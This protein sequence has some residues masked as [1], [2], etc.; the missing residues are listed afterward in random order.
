MHFYSVAISLTIVC[1]A[2]LIYLVMRQEW[3]GNRTNQAFT[4]YLLSMALWLAAYVMV[5]ISANAEEALFWYR[6][7]AGV[8]SGQF[9]LYY[10][11]TRALLNLKGGR[12]LAL[13]GPLVWAL[14]VFL[15]V[16]SRQPA[17][18]AGIHR[19]VATGLFVP[20]FGP[21]MLLFAAPN[22]F[23]LGYAVY[24]LVRGYRSTRSELQR[25][26]I[27]YLLVGLVVVVIGIAVNFVP[28][29]QPYPIDVAA[30]LVNAAIIA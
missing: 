16:G 22:Y 26:R 12:T 24:N 10:V 30:N 17:I 9:I 27:Q 13:A 23:Y 14:T 7:V 5:S 1:Y 2:A 6:I 28:R 11:F 21:L 20:T 25:S 8:V 4:L 15:G 18:Y 29:L 3:R 19:D